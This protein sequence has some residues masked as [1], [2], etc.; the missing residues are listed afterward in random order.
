YKVACRSKR[1]ATD[2]PSLQQTDRF[3]LRLAV[4]PFP[5]LLWHAIPSFP[6]ARRRMPGPARTIPPPHSSGNFVIDER[7]SSSSS[8]RVHRLGSAIEKELL[9]PLRENESRRG[10]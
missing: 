7:R 1:R 10:G 8:S 2:G 5:H 4:R 3:H 6:D 9:L